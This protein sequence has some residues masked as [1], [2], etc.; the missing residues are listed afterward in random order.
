[1]V[2]GFWSLKIQPISRFQEY[3]TIEGVSVRLIIFI[4]VKNG[5]G[6]MSGYIVNELCMA[7]CAENICSCCGE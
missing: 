7:S 1:M 6:L 3:G 2:G 5:I 4:A